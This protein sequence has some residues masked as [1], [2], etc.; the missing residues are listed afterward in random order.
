[1]FHMLLFQIPV[2]SHTE[3]SPFW[4]SFHPAYSSQWMF[5]FVLQK[6]LLAFLETPRNMECIHKLAIY[7]LYTVNI[8]N[9]IS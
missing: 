3:S 5:H 6:L 4:T 9:A 8:K 1:M 7:K 2:L